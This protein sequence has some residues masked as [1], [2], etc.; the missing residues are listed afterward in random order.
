MLVLRADPWAPDYGM[1]FEAPQELPEDALPR[2]DPF[3]E[4]DDRVAADEE[5]DEDSILSLGREERLETLSVKV[6]P[7][8]DTEFV[9][10]KCYLVK[11]IRSQLADKKR[12]YCRDCV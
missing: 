1:G 3:V 8:Q 2:A 4:T 9:C 6:I 11:P 5:E 10:R 12:M 7:K